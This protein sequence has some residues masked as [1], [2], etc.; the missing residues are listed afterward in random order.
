MFLNSWISSL[1]DAIRIYTRHFE[2]DILSSLSM[3]VKHENGCLNCK[4]IILNM[5]MIL[6]QFKQ[7]KNWHTIVAI[8]KQLKHQMALKGIYKI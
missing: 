8:F 2:I 1:N 5:R 7:V 6:G 4:T 3:A